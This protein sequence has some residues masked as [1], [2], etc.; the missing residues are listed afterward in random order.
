MLRHE[1]RQ[2]GIGT[3]GVIGGSDIPVSG[4]SAGS[5]GSG[6]GEI[7]SWMEA[8]V[9]SEFERSGLSSDRI[10]LLPPAALGERQE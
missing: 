1:Q 2:T 10:G 7:S 3:G 6:D 4:T 9:K 8:G 5:S